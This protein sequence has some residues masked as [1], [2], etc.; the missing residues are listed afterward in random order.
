M[1]ARYHV[2]TGG[3]AAAVLVPALGAGSAVFFA[4]AVLIDGDHYL[5]YIYRNGFRDFS[6]R[7]MFRFHQRLNEK[8]QRQSL[9]V[10]NLLH[11][12][13]AL[14]ILGLAS[15]VS[16]WPWLQ[17]IFWGM[18]F[19]LVT[20]WV[21]LYSRGRFSRRAMSLVEYMVRWR[22]LKRRNLEPERIY[23]ETMTDIGLAPAAATGS[24]TAAPLTGEPD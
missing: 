6:L 23:R 4:T 17:A 3:V 1:Q 11:T 22:S 21:F 24:G 8:G 10:L 13:E 20:D 7:S 16:G 5:D 9:L 2:L 15:A 12:V 18:A 19:H 14:A